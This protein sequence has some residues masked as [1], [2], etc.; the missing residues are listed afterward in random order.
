[1][2]DSADDR[3]SSGCATSL[4]TKQSAFYRD[5]I[6]RDPTQ[7]SEYSD[8]RPNFLAYL[9]RGFAGGRDIQRSR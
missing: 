7:I 9:M 8:G 5:S 6:Y 3:A 4:G 2:A 1:M